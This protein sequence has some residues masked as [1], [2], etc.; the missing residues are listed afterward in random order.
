MMANAARPKETESTNDREYLSEWPPTNDSCELERCVEKKRPRFDRDEPAGLKEG[1]E[2]SREDDPD[3]LVLWARPALA[4][5]WRRRQKERNISE[6]TRLPKSNNPNTLLKF[7]AC[8]PEGRAFLKRRIEALKTQ[9]ALKPGSAAQ[10][11]SLASYYDLLQDT[12]SALDSLNIATALNPQDKNIAWLH[13][14]VNRRHYSTLSCKEFLFEYC[15]P[16]IPV[17]ITGVVEK[18]TSV[19]W[20]FQHIKKIAGEKTAPL[21]RVVKESTEWAKLE[22]ACSM[23]ISDFIDSLGTLQ[24]P[25]YLFDWSIPTH[26]PEL[27]RELVIPKYFAGD[28]LQRT[29]SGSL[30]KDS[31]PSLFIAPQGVHSDLHVD[32]FGSN[33]WM[34]LFQGTKRWTFFSREDTPLLYPHYE[35]SMDLVFDVDLSDPDFDKH[36]LLCTATAKQCTLQPGELLFVPCGCPH[37]VENL[38]DSLAISAN[39]VDLSNYK[40][41]IEELTANALVDPCAEELLTQ[42]TNQ[43][44]PTRMCSRQRDLPWH[45]FK[46]WSRDNYEECDIDIADVNLKKTTPTQTTCC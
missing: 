43:D 23:K 9:I 6:F 10:H 40:V 36:P 4:R 7:V 34:A 45:K 21:K 29:A 16:G 42:L 11:S 2:S 46:I 38:E 17:I 37:R 3:E 27:A 13:L 26:A 33:F 8:L 44:F 15:V 19:S 24:E 25:L 14:K 1:R 18:L 31:W 5:W 30:Y 20:T 12:S 22:S 32:A 35:N 41:V 39:F 28:F